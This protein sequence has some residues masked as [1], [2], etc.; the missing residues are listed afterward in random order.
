LIKHSFFG[1]KKN[2]FYEFLK[3]C[4]NYF[5]VDIALECARM[6]HRFSL[7]P[8]EV[9]DFPQVGMNSELKM[10][11]LVSGSM[12]GTRNETDILQEILSVAQ[13]SQELINQS[14]YSH[15]FGGNE[16]YATDHENDFTFMV[17]NNYNHVTDHMNSMRYI[18]DKAWED[19][20]TRSIEIG[21]LDNEFKAERMV[22]NLRWVGMS[23]ND[24]EKVC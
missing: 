9:E 3:N 17:G 6:Q 15:A 7:P 16:N 2:H 21:D 22:E 19:P 10:T 14:N 1:E 4:L 13:A 5:Q 8:L 24:L 11:Q 23:S 12:S 20:N 18:D